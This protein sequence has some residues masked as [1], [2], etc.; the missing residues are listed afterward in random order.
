MV[1]AMKLTIRFK[2][3]TVLTVIFSSFLVGLALARNDND[4]HIS[5]LLPIVLLFAFSWRR[6]TLILVA[7]AALLGLC[8]GILRGHAFLSQLQP[9]ETLYGEESTIRVQAGTDAVYANGGQLEFDAYHVEI[10]RPINLKLPGKIQ[11][12]GRGVPIVYRGD[13]VEVTGSMYPTGGARQGRISFAEIR[14]VGRSGSL[15]ES[16]RRKFVAGM[17]TALPEP[18]A[19]FGLGILIGQR[20]TLPDDLSEQLS[21]VGLTHIIAVSGYNLTI[22][23]RGVRRKLSRLSKYQSTVLSL[24]LMAG[25]LLLTGFSASIVRASMVTSL[26]LAAWYYGRKFKPLLLIS[27]TAAVTA[28][29]N[30][31]YLWSDIGWYLSFLA[32]FGVLILAPLLKTCIFGMKEQ[33]FL[34]QVVLESISAQI[35]VTPLILYIFSEA[36]LIALPSNVIVVPLVP[37]AMIFSVVAGIAGMLAPVVSGLFAW[38]GT[39]LMTYML[40]I[41]NLF[42][43]IPYAKVELSLSLFG[44]LLAY[45]LVITCM[46]V[47]AHKA[48]TRYG[49][50]TDKNII[51]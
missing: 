12:R 30:P 4:L 38:P 15:V 40:D 45:S 50:I 6:K 2:Q 26:S 9:Y 49:T 22:I 27:L 36:S 16:I 43:R 1:N 46:L 35:M 48:K 34:G 29:G 31:V 32:F 28:M 47:F 23:I 39:I 7:S 42:S 8:G 19:S 10:L 21:I 41:V 44:M 17:Q 24:V 13:I 14:V 37:F 18:L 51:E 11:V 20:T 5:W 33:K 3:T 25:F